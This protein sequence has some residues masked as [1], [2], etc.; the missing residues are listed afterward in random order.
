[1]AVPK[2]KTTKHNTLTRRS[3]NAVEPVASMNCP[4]CGGTK[5]PHNVCPKCGSYK[6]KT[7]VAVKK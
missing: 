7:V 4:K 3:H 2:Q 1:M 6:D 5:L